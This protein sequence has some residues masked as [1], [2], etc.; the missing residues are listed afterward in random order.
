MNRTRGIGLFV[1]AGGLAGYLV[2]VQIPYP[3]R[4]L[5]LIA[6]MVGITITAVGV[7]DP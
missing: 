3:A 1:T 4:E 6:V 7:D 5:S 2:G